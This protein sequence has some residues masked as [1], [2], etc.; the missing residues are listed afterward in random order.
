[1]PSW[2]RCAVISRDRIAKSEASNA[3]VQGGVAPLNADPV[4]TVMNVQD[5]GAI[6]EIVGAAAVVASLLY[7]AIQ[8]RQSSRIAKASTTQALLG[9]SAQMNTAAA[10]DIAPVMAKVLSDQDLTPTERYQYFAYM[11]AAFAQCW[12]AHH[13]HVNGML[14]R[15]VFEAYERRTL[16]FLER[17][18]AREFW[19]RNR[20][21]F[22]TTFSEYVDALAE[23]AGA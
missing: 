1:M 5:L 2:P 18:I 6:G 19:E 21:R 8:I 9:Y 14:E 4:G 23:R 20:F 12:Q 7:L 22:S 17:P 3:A 15:E 16:S 11:L 13:Q 10:G